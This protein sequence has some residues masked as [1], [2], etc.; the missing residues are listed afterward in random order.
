MDFFTAFRIGF[1]TFWTILSAE[2][3]L[4]MTFLAIFIGTIIWATLINFIRQQK[5]KKSG[6]LEIDK[7]PGKVFEEYLQVLMRKRGYK[8]SL[9]PATGDYGADL[10]LSTIDKKIVV[11]AKRYKKKVGVKAVQEIVSAKNYYNADECWVVTNNFFTA[12]AVKLA[13]SNNVVLIDR[14]QLMKWMLEMNKGA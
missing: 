14:E 6:M 12:P 4:T 9:T 11:Q 10:I 3:K 13:S 8:V 7:M 2:P 5:L 1:E